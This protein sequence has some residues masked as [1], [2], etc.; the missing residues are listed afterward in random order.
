M[1]TFLIVPF[2]VDTVSTLPGYVYYSLVRT[3][4]T[5]NDMELLR[6]CASEARQTSIEL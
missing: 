3:L 5:I 1:F 4:G 2:E 6:P